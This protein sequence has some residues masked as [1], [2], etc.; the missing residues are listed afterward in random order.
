MTDTQVEQLEQTRTPLRRFELK[1]PIS[2]TVI[3]RMT[4][5]GQYVKAGE[6]IYKLA[7]LSSV[8]L[9]LEL[10]PQDAADV[11]VGQTVTA[12]TQSTKSQTFTGRVE[13]VEPTV[14]PKR[15]TVG[16]R[17]AISNP[18][19]KLKPGEFARA[20]L[21][22]PLISNEGDVNK[23]VVIPRNS[24]LSIG[25]TALAYV[26]TKP[27]EFELRHLKV[28]PTSDGMVVVYEGIRSGEQVIARSTFLLDAQMQLQGNPSLIDPNK[29]VA[30]AANERPLTA[31]ELEEIRLA[32]EPLSAADRQLAEAQVICPVTEVRLGSMGMG[33]PIKLEIDGRTVFICCEGCRDSWVADPEKYFK[34]LDDYLSGATKTPDSADEAEAATR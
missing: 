30:L 21:H 27:G 15:R 3:E 16:V 34:I 28:G 33:T 8:W 13:F 6:P 4:S 11:A 31:A 20:E 17:V 32:M 12:T 19:G 2:G 29:A 24:L 14:D 23:A 25:E 26:E 9:E 5:T 18:E 10:F 7:D 1:A 22:L